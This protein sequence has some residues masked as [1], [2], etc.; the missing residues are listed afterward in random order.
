MAISRH[1]PGVL[2]QVRAGVGDGVVPDALLAVV[3]AA[4]TTSLEGNTT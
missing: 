4:E 2:K 1:S 3:E